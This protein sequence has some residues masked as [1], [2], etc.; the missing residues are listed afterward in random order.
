MKKI[1]TK[2]LKNSNDLIDVPDLEMLRVYQLGSQANRVN[3]TNRFVRFTLSH[4]LH[5]PAYV[6]LI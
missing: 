3:I 4:V 2:R 1:L 6:D 5:S